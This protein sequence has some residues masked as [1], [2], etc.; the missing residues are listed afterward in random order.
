MKGLLIKDLKLMLAQKRFFLIVFGMGIMLMF[1]NGEPSTSIG[2]V[3]LLATMFALNTVS[4]DEHEQGMNFLLTL[5]I[6]RKTYVRE[7]YVF[8]GILAIVA[9]VVAILLA[10]MATMTRGVDQGLAEICVIAVIMFGIALAILAVT[11]PLKL[12]FG[13]EK[14]QMAL[15]AVSAMIGIVIA[16]S[17]SLAEKM[18]SDLELAIDTILGQSIEKIVLLTVFALI[19]VLLASYFASMHIVNKKEY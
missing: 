19:L 16:L 7:K 4:Y 9:T 14:G 11:L 2:Y 13:A 17:F 6:S 1:A 10:Y 12:K 3:I 18:G 8:A 5:P 15:F